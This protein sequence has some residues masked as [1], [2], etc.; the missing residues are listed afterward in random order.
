MTNRVHRLIAHRHGPVLIA[1]TV[2]A[3]VAAL[4]V[5]PAQ[6]FMVELPSLAFYCTYLGLMAWRLPDLTS[7]Y[8]RHNAEEADE[9]A[10]LIIV[11]TLLAVIISIAALFLAVNSDDKGLPRLVTAFLAV[12]AGWATIHTM[13]A[14]HYAH[15]FWRPETTESGTDNK[16]GLSFPETDEP[17][18]WDFLYFSFVVGM[19]AQTSDTAITAT[20]MRRINMLHAVVSYLFN[21]VLIAAAVNGAVQLAG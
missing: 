19:T 20:R 6:S 16:G 13:A 15:L 1:L 17:C 7:D 3:V 11:V 12:I 4:T 8:L 2:A 9:P 14:I 5:V 10:T 18:G 21:T